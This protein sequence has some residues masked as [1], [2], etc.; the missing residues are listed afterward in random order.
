MAVSPATI[1]NNN[2]NSAPLESYAVIGD[3]ETAALVSLDGSMDW[4]C[5]PTFASDACLARL[6]GTEENGR[7]LL[8]P[9]CEITKTS[10][11]YLDHT[12]ILET[13]FE[14]N[15]GAV[16]L[17]D[18]MPIRGTNSDVVR[19]VKGI[20][21]TVPMKM[22]LAL[23]FGYGRIVPWVTQ[24]E[25]GWKAIAGPDL[26]VLRTTAPLEGRDLTT[27]SEFTVGA[28]DSVEFAMT[29]GASHLHLPRAIDVPR[30]L[31][32]TRK[33]WEEWVARCKYDGPHQPAVERSLITLKALTY[34][35][36]GGV[37]AA[38]TTSL[39]EQIGGPRNWDYRYCWLRDTTFTLLALMN[40]GYFQEARQ[41]H[42]WLLRAVAGSPDQ[43]Q[44]MYGISGERYLLEWE[45]PW[46]DGYE[47]SKPVRVGNAASD[48]LQLDIYGE[49]MDAFFHAESRL[50]DDGRLNFRMLRALVQ[51]LEQ[52][53]A[54]PDD[55]IWETRGGR[56][57]F[58]Y[59]KVMAWVAFDRAILVA[60]KL[61]PDAPVARWEKVRDAIHSEVCE[62]AYSAEL[63][64]FV[65][66][67]GSS[68][69]DAATLLIP[70]V[71][72]L[73]HDDPRVRGTM[74]AIERRLMPDGLVMRYDTATSNDGLPPGEG[75]FL[76]CSF[77]MVSNLKAV[78]READAM[79]LFE[80]VLALAN[81]VG[82]L[83]EEYDVGRQRLVGNFPQAFSHIALANAAFDLA[84]HNGSSRR[85]SRRSHPPTV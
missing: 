74:E 61:D 51:H 79:K 22:E 72:F 52:I 57:H 6:L 68:Q 1:M 40:G 37:V 16:Q 18:F 10:R 29:Y 7:W 60:K 71:G 80:R 78:G 63:G 58:T 41:W 67:Y 24:G 70:L 50:G 27:V 44:I 32:Q 77:W 48:Q 5:W 75:V 45:L 81:D 55:G 38:V 42:Q 2:H 66:A 8:T 73:P 53:W 21:G 59:S 20:R 17:I 47:R 11:K 19:I 28:G 39:P 64:S 33:Y 4:L 31:E 36:T 25:D 85:H 49:V 14:T 46:L 84:N 13:T 82:L 65:Q 3:C 62:K 56:Q 30:A 35:P 23:R 83:A 76:A 54:E 15:E 12:L 43:V 26:V 69:L 34:G 9:A